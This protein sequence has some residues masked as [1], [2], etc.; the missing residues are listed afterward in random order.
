M[1]NGTSWK[2]LSGDFWDH[3]MHNIDM[4]TSVMSPL[5]RAVEVVVNE[6]KKQMVSMGAELKEYPLGKKSRGRSSNY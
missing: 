6:S 4:T 2:K 1:Y 3:T 5:A